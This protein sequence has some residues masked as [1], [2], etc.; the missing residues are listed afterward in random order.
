MELQLL[1]LALPAAPSEL[2]TAVGEPRQITFGN[3]E[4]HVHGGGW[5]WDGSAV[6]YSRDADRGD[7]YVIEPQR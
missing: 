5:A 3:G 2:P 7:I 1:R 6:V 4:W